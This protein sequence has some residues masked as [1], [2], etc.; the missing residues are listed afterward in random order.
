MNLVPYRLALILVLTFAPCTLTFAP[1]ICGV[2]FLS[3]GAS[4]PLA[5]TVVVTGCNLRW[6]FFSFNHWRKHPLHRWWCHP[7]QLALVV[8][9]L[10]PTGAHLHLHLSNLTVWWWS[11]VCGGGSCM[12]VWLVIVA[13]GWYIYRERERKQYICNV[14]VAII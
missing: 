2:I 4:S 13:L 6:C 1:C 11:A 7:L 9:F 5:H 3:T 14:D 8:F 12:G 10:P